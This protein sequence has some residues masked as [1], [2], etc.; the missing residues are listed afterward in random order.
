MSVYKLYSAGAGGTENNA[1]ALD[2]QFDGNITGLA[3]TS[4][5]DFDAADESLSVEISF[6]STGTFTSNDARGSLLM[7][8][9]KLGVLTSG[10]MGPMQMAVSGLKIPVNQGERIHL[11]ISSTAGVVSQNQAYIYVD[12]G[13][14][15]SRRRR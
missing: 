9:N 1:A 13:Q 14:D 6:L 7:N 12:D 15:S 3:M 5:G 11:H 4:Y 8:T 10:S 2:V